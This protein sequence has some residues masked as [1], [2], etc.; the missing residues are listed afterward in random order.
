MTKVK[1]DSTITR[2]SRTGSEQSK[3]AKFNKPANRRARRNAARIM[4]LDTLATVKAPIV[5]K[6]VRKSRAKVWTPGIDPIDQ[7]DN[8]GESPDC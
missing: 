2:A 5:K 8:L 7:G 1:R 4:A 6:R 3:N